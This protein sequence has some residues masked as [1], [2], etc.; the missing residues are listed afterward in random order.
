MEGVVK[1]QNVHPLS[2]VTLR[3][4]K[5][6]FNKENIK[7]DTIINS[8]GVEQAG[9]GWFTSNYISIMGGANIVFSILDSSSGAHIAF[10]RS[11]KQYIEGSSISNADIITLYNLKLTIP[12]NASY[13]RFTRIYGASI[14]NSTQLEYGNESTGYKSFDGNPYTPNFLNAQEVFTSSPQQVISVD[15]F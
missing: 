14:L 1:T 6:L 8:N 15:P 11:D 3:S 2:A 9:N 12:S 13:L 4:G 10:L 7:I 5:N